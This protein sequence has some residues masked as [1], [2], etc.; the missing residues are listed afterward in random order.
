MRLLS[1]EIFGIKNTFYIKKH[2]SHQCNDVVFL[3]NYYIIACNNGSI[4]FTTN[5]CDYRTLRFSSN[6]A[7]ENFIKIITFNNKWVAISENGYVVWG[8]TD[9]NNGY[10]I[11]LDTTRLYDITTDGQKVVISASGCKA[12]ITEDLT[13]WDEQTIDPTIPN[14]TVNYWENIVFNGSQFVVLQSILS[15]NKSYVKFST[16][17]INWGNAI[18]CPYRVSDMYYI[19]G[20][21]FLLRINGYWHTTDF[22]NY[23]NLV[24]T[25]GVPQKCFYNNDKLYIACYDTYGQYTQGNIDIINNNNFNRIAETLKVGQYRLKSLYIN[26]NRI[27]CCGDGLPDDSV[28]GY[29]SYRYNAG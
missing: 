18:S 19:D 22:N 16:D 27:F 17:L 2:S 25:N 26:N 8:D 24:F 5:C 28:S 13:N 10:G 9:P 7:D 20:K 21:Y 4:A 15:D 3:D 6:I 23:S 29:V 12:F 1:K 14:G 11:K